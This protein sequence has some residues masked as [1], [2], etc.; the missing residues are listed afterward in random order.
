MSFVFSVFFLIVKKPDL[1]II[2]V[3]TGDVGLG[4]LIACRL[5]GVKT[6]VDYRD[7]W[8]D[9]ASSMSDN[10]NQKSFYRLVKQG[11]TLLYSKSCLTVTVTSGFLSNLKSRGVANIVL[12]PNGAD[13]SVFCPLVKSETRKKLNL[14]ESDFV[15]VY[16][17]IIGGYYKLDVVIKLLANIRGSTGS[18][19]FLIVGEGSELPALKKLSAQLGLNDSVFYLGVKN[20]LHDV[21]EIISASD[22]GIIPGIYTKGQLAVK[23]FEYCSCGVPVIAVAPDDSIIVNLIDEYRVGLSIPSMD[24]IK[25]AKTIH[26]LYTDTAFRVDA[27]KRARALIEEKFNRN[28]TAEQYLELIEG[29]IIKC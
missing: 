24:E 18:F 5:S 11:M 21:A 19:K 3:P 15:I 4:A 7:E 20:N 10:E 6:V 1:A 29:L 22:V 27:G 26:K 23:F 25:L 13:T 17:G 2:S 14:S 8:E 16:S 9:F 28:K 12:M